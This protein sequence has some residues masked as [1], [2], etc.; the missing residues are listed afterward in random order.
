MP[1]ARATTK[2]SRTISRTMTGR[3]VG[4]QKARWCVQ[5][6]Y[7]KIVQGGS[8]E[9]YYGNSSILYDVNLSFYFKYTQYGL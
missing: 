6:D 1:R 9:F 4:E 7:P 8:T 3:G 2:T 5:C